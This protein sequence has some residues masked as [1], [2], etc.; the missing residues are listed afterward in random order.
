MI[1]ALIQFILKLCWW[2]Y[3]CV[4]SKHLF[5]V[6]KLGLLNPIEVNFSMTNKC[7]DSI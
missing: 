2:L 3:I 6:E 1:D 7:F 5:V 4:L